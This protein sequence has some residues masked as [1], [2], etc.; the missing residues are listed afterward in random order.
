MQVLILELSLM[1]KLMKE[2]KL[3]DAI[4]GDSF[5]NADLLFLAINSTITS[6]LDQLSC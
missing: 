1:S 3:L 4:N 2:C 6:F 5:V